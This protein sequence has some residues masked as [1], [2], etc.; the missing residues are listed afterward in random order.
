MLIISPIIR[1][2]AQSSAIMTMAD[3]GTQILVEGKNFDT[4]YSLER[5]LRWT[6]A[7]LLL[8]GPYFFMG[9]AMLDR[10]FGAAASLRGVAMK[11]AAAQFV[12]FPP[13]L[14]AIFAFM[15]ILERHPNIVEKIKTRVP[16]AFAS[17]C[18]YWPAV[19]CVTFSCIPPALRV[20][21]V[22]VSAGFWNS[23]L[24]WTNSKAEPVPKLNTS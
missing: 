15:G 5:T 1:A 18:C 20:P 21:F 10:R 16:T 2:G 24:S 11:T 23:F 17:G 3:V 6:M 22:A 12:L 8:H 13:Y 7:G 4:G 9:Y 19:N 14:V